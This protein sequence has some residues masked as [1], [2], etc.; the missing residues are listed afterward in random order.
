MTTPSIAKSNVLSSYSEYLHDTATTVEPSQ[1]VTAHTLRMNYAGGQIS[2]RAS[3]DGHIALRVYTT[4]GQQVA[5]GTLMLHQ[6]FGA[7]PVGNLPAGLYVARAI[8]ESG[9]SVSCKFVQGR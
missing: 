8:D 3:H 6:G 9:K 4:G 7:W 1:I 5:S 2:V